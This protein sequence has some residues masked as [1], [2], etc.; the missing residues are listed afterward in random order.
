[1]YQVAGFSNFKL[2]A[3]LEELDFILDTLPLAKKVADVE[4]LDSIL[5][6]VFKTIVQEVYFPNGSKVII[7]LLKALRAINQA[8]RM[9]RI[10]VL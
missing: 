7:K 10:Q 4:A 9:D 8:C 2:S 6:N 5:A 1:M 3:G